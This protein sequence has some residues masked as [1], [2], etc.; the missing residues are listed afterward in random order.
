VP[1]VGSFAKGAGRGAGY[2]DLSVCGGV[3]RN[4]PRVV[5]LEVAFFLFALP[6]FVGWPSYFGVQIVFAR[7]MVGVIA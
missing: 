5:F 4:P 6:L 3:W 1:V 7:A 2:V